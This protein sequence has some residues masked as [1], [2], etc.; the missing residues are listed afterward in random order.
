MPNRT[1]DSFAPSDIVRIAPTF[2]TARRHAIQALLQTLD[3]LHHLPRKI[4]V[5]LTENNKRLE[6]GSYDPKPVQIAISRYALDPGATFIHEFGHYLDNRI[7]HPLSSEY[8]SRYEEEFDNLMACCLSSP[9]VLKITH[10]L[11]TRG[12]HLRASD[13]SYLK[14]ALEPHEV[15]ARAYF[16]WVATR[17]DTPLLRESLNLRMNLKLV[18]GGRALIFQWDPAEFDDII[19]ELESIFRKKGLL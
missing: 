18:F 16:Q 15:F 17:S 13:I 9:A 11:K 4:P 3:H 10:T 12:R 6:Q 8:A 7:L 14:E 19:R 1:P 2:P 5:T